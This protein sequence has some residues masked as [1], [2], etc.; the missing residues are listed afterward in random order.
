L[1]KYQQFQYFGNQRTRHFRGSNIG[2]FNG[3]GVRGI[4]AFGETVPLQGIGHEGLLG[5]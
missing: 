3:W 4:N 5:Y 2:E 1:S